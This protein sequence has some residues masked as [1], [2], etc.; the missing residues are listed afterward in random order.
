M[1]R[2]S[3]DQEATRLNE[4]PAVHAAHLGAWARREEGLLHEEV[5]VGQPGA[6][7]PPGEHG[8]PAQLLNSPSA[9]TSQN[10]G[11]EGMERPS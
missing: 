3:L 4:V 7:G 1:S 6:R 8:P 11:L 5:Q 2:T 9:G 10:H